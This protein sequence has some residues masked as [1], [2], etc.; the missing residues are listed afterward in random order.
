MF[1]NLKVGDSVYHIGAGVIAE[2]VT[3]VGRKFFY[4][5][6]RE[7]GRELKFVKTTGELVSDHRHMVVSLDKK[8]LEDKVERDNIENQIYRFYC[9]NWDREKISKRAKVSLEDLRVI[10]EILKKSEAVSEDN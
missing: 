4:T 1:E 10:S 8:A 3:K 6:R 2:T 7:H 5:N 9:D